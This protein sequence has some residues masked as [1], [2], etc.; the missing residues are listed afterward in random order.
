MM[1]YDRN[2]KG[3]PTCGHDLGI[4]TQ[5]GAHKFEHRSVLKCSNEKCHR[6]WL[7]IRTLTQIAVRGMKK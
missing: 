5:S 6:E 7:Y 3:C 1:D 2:V 4:V